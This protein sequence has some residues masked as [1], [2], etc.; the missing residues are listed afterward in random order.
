[1]SKR[2]VAKHG[3]KVYTTSVGLILSFLIVFF[4]LCLLVFRVNTGDKEISIT[5]GMKM[6]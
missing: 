5:E 1:M 3:T 2:Q 6:L 4:I